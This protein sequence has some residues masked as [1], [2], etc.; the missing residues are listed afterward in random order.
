MFYVPSMSARTVV[1]KGMLLANQ[2][3]EYY[4]DLQD[5][6]WESAWRW[7]TSASP[8]TPSRPG[9]WPIPSA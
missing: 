4:L 6:R 2:V 5:P 7:C 1:Y 3:G 8:P 9:T